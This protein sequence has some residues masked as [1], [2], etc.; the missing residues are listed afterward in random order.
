VFTGR[1]ESTAGV[2]AL[3]KLS[4]EDVP[5]RGVVSEVTDR[6]LQS[7]RV[8]E[9]LRNRAKDAKRAVTE[10]APRGLLPA[11]TM[12]QIRDFYSSSFGGVSGGL[13]QYTSAFF[14]RNAEVSR[15]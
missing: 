10:D 3:A 11:M 8:S 15:L 13:A 12:E 7:L 2:S 9:S 6:V 5:T 1:V 14:K 4:L